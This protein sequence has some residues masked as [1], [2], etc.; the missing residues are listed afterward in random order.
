MQKIHKI[1]K[2][3]AMYS[4][5]SLMETLVYIGLFGMLFIV[6]VQFMLMVGDNNDDIAIRAD[7]GIYKLYTLEHIE[8]SVDWSATI[9]E[10]NSVFDVDNGVLVLANGSNTVKYELSNGDLVVQRDLDTPVVIT[11]NGVIVTLFRLDQLYDIDS[12]LIGVEVNLSYYMED[13]PNI[14]GNIKHVYRIY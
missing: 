10:A 11:P 6:L 12:S 8:E 9:D 1:Q 14:T 4:G 7:S 13:K 5:L 3:K 2:Q